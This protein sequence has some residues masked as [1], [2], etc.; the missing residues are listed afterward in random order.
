M[1]RT[2]KPEVDNKPNA[3]K[4]MSFEEFLDDRKTSDA[5]FICSDD[6]KVPVHRVLL[7]K[8][9]AVFREIFQDSQKQNTKMPVF[10]GVDSQTMKE[11]LKH[12]YTG[13][14]TLTDIDLISKVYKAA[15]RFELSELQLQC[16]DAL[17][18]QINIEKVLAILETAN[19]LGLGELE[20]KAV[21]FIM[22]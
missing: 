17:L 9:S 5:T 14:A 15:Q 18:N 11:V 8:K 2:Q 4:E 12:V 10:C 1:K 3:A 21:S 16:V 6:K 22:K 19:K 20:A 13:N 7:M